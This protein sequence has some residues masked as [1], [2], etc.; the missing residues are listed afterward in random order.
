MTHNQ[1]KEQLIG[2]DPEMTQMLESAG[3]IFEKAVQTIF[4]KSKI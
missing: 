2:T 4:K 3:K 1:Q